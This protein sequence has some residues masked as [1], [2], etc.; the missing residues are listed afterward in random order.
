VDFPPSGIAIIVLQMAVN[1]HPP[2]VVARTATAADL[3]RLTDILASSFFGDPTWG[4]L[5]GEGDRRRRAMGSLLGFFANSALR[6]PWVLLSEAGESAA[7]WIPPGEDE[8]APEDNEPFERLIHEQCGDGAADLLEAL[9]RFELA[10]PQRLHFYLSLLG[11]HDDSR[12]R[13]TGMG[14]L[15]ESLRRIDAL[16]MPCYLESTNPVNDARYGRQGFEPVGSFTVPTGAVVTTMWR[17]PRGESA[18]P[19]DASRP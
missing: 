11:T 15:A 14:L 4:P 17:E 19:A 7:V 13:G 3:G 10:R 1:G 9:E 16:G 8:L 12:G 2:A 5:L 18:A 6:F